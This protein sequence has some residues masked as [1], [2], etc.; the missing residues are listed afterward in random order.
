MVKEGSKRT[1]VGS[2]PRRCECCDDGTGI[3][4]AETINLCVNVSAT[5]F[6]DQRHYR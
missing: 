2:V 4:D 1:V 3:L 6:Q 5:L